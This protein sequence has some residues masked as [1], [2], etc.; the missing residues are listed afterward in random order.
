MHKPAVGPKIAPAVRHNKVNDVLPPMRRKNMLMLEFESYEAALQNGTL[1]GEPLP[2]IT[3]TKE[4]QRS[5]ELR[6]SH[7]APAHPKAKQNSPAFDS[8]TNRPHSVAADQFFGPIVTGEK[9][10][11]TTEAVASVSKATVDSQSADGVF[12]T[13]VCKF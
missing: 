9:Q 11:N 1:Y 2:P 3:P 6:E 13:Q 5:K 8:S 12:L 7:S 4:T 10:G